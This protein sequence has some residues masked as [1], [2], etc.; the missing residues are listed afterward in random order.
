[1]RA[2][3]GET[4]NRPRS[5][6]KPPLRDL[7]EIGRDDGAAPL[8][9]LGIAVPKPTGVKTAKSKAQA[10]DKAAAKRKAKQEALASIDAGAPSRL[11]RTLRTFRL[12]RRDC[13][14]RASND[15]RELTTPDDGQESVSSPKP[16]SIP[17]IGAGLFF[18]RQSI[19]ARSAS[20][21]AT[22]ARRFFASGIAV[23]SCACSAR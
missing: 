21:L 8:K 4:G 7:Y 20:V 18:L 10:V 15:R 16:A 17:V 2:R 3:R 13:A 5:I 19:F 1:M 14:I 23:A 22:A 12:P 6:A 11:R 9:G